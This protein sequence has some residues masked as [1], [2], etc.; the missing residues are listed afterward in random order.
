VGQKLKLERHILEFGARKQ[1]AAV[2]EDVLRQLLSK[3]KDHL[4][5]R[6]LPEIKKLV[7]SYVE[8][9]IV[10]KEHVDLILKLHLPE[11]Q[12]PQPHAVVDLHGGGEGI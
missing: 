8:K 7:A 10:Y 12:N 6:N 11:M 5:N 2:T 9:V 1:K 3:F 4:A